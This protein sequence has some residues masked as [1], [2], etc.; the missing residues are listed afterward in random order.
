MEITCLI[1]AV[2]GLPLFNANFGQKVACL[3][4]P[5][6]PQE[7]IAVLDIWL[8]FGKRMVKIDFFSVVLSIFM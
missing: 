5:C 8:D 3:S 7:S 6:G 4:N 1:R 2:I